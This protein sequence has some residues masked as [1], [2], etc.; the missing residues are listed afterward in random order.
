MAAIHEVKMEVRQNRLLLQAFVNRQAASETEEDN[1]IVEQLDLPFKD[2]QSV[3]LAEI[4][5]QDK[6]KKKQLVSLIYSQLG[7]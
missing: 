3:Q 7:L 2:I 5:L 4:S 6:A 1:R